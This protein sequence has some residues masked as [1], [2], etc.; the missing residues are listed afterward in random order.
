MNRDRFSCEWLDETVLLLLVRVQTGH[1]VLEVT[2]KPRFMFRPRHADLLDEPADRGEK[3]AVLTQQGFD[4]DSVDRL[5]IL[6]TVIQPAGILLVREMA[7]E[8]L[9]KLFEYGSQPEKT[10]MVSKP[11]E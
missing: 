9:V 2:Q 7:D 8:E 10:A 5:A 3:G 4:F 11:P 6:E 1:G